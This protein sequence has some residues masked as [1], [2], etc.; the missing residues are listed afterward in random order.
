M[1][2]RSGSTSFPALQ[3]RKPEQ[4]RLSSL[5]CGPRCLQNIHPAALSV[6]Y[7]ASGE[8]PVPHMDHKAGVDDRIRKE[9]PE[10]AAKTTYVWM[11][12]YSANMASFHSFVLLSCLGQEENGSGCSPRVET[13]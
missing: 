3:Q 5:R 12:W 11:G 13:L 9:L 2:L 10:L 1:F 8:R 6:L 7:T 4:K